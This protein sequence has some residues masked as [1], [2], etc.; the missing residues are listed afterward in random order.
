MPRGDS[1]TDSTHQSGAEVVLDMFSGRPNPKWKL[2]VTQVEELKSKLAGLP[3]SRP[4]EPP[5]LGYRGIVIINHSKDPELPSHIRAYDSVLAVAK[6]GK[7]TYFRD[8]NRIEDWLLGLGKALGYAAL[9]DK[10][11]KRAN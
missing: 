1:E 10:A 9:I 3:L 6:T 5:G 8:V 7:M 4:R 2:S 11:R